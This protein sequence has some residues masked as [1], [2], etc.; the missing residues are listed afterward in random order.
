MS[1]S[2]YVSLTDGSTGNKTNLDVIIEL[3]IESLSLIIFSLGFP[4]AVEENANIVH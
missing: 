1:F 3:A 2:L 4:L